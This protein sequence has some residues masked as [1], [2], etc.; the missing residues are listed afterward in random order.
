[1]PQV[2][3]DLPQPVLDAL[4]DRSE[5]SGEPVERVAAR[6]LADALQ[7]GHSTVFQVSTA[8]ALMAGVADGAV[9]VAD[10]LRH[11][12]FG[13]GTFAGWDGEMV[14]LDGIAYQVTRDGV[15]VAPGDAEVPFALVTHFV[16][17]RQVD[18]GEV[19]SVDVLFG[20]LDGLRDSDNE[21]F[22]VRVDG[23][24]DRLE[25][26]AVCASGK[27]TPLDVAARSQ[28]EFELSEV[29]ATL[30]GYWSPPHLRSIGVSGWHLHALTGDRTQGGHLLGC[31]GGPLTA[32]VQHL[33]DFRLAIPE[34]P[35]FQHAHLSADLGRSL[36]AVESKPRP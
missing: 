4:R 24:L 33:A 19:D 20:L 26:R 25:T 8:S 22:A 1:M 16:P 12:D 35:A 27:S 36:D 13:L 17:E 18:V 15:R 32:G 30:V 2:S 3:F 5:Q 14:V 10:L 11:G 29:D 21:F 7:V 31:R 34:T 9:T 28:A 23:H 6:A